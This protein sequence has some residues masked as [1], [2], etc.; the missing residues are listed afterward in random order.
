MAQGGA[1]KIGC[2]TTST[3][4][5]PAWLTTLLWAGTAALAAQTPDTPLTALADLLDASESPTQSALLAQHLSLVD[6]QLFHFCQDRGAQY[7]SA[8]NPSRALRSYS[9]ALAVAIKLED[10]LAVAQA[11]S[12][13][14]LA[15]YRQGRM[16][17]ALQAYQNGLQA[18]QSSGAQPQVAELLRRIGVAERALGDMTA[19]SAADEQSLEIFQRLDDK[20]GVI[21][22]LNGMGNSHARLGELRQAAENF[23]QCS[24]LGKAAGSKEIVAAAT[25]SLGNVYSMQGDTAL[26]LTYLEKALILKKEANASKRDLAT[27]YVNLIAGYRQVGRYQDALRAADRCLA[28]AREERDE[29]TAGYALLNRAHVYQEAHRYRES[30]ADA[31]ASL[32]IHEKNK[33]PIEVAA[34]LN[35]IARIELDLG[36]NPS[37]LDTARRASE[38]ARQ[39]SAPD[40]LW[41]ALESEAIAL[42]RLHQSQLALAAYAEGAATVDTL[43]QRLAGGEAQGLEFLRDKMNL[44]YGLME[45]SIQL[46]QAEEAL[47]V[48]ER[49]KSG[50]ILDVLRAGR[51]R[52]TT[53]MTLAEQHRE[54][55]LA[56]RLSTVK[57]PAAVRD[58]E[59]FRSEL[60]AA[61]PGLKVRRGICDPVSVEAAA[62]LLPDTRTALLEF[63]VA[64]AATYLFVIS[65]DGAGSPKL[66]LH[67]LPWKQEDL[68]RE[69]EAFRLKLASRDLSYRPAA[70]SLYRRLLGPAAEALKNK[71]LLA[72]VPDGPLWS[73]PF[74]ALLQPNGRHVIED[75]AVF[76]APSFT[77]LVEMVRSRK[78]VL[79]GARTLLAMGDPQVKLG[80]AAREVAALGRLYGSGSV[81]LTGT[82]ASESQWKALAPQHRILHLAT[83]GVLNSANPLY[84]YVLLS[85]GQG[86]DGIVEAREILDLDLKAELVVLSAC[87]TGRGGFRHGEGLVGLSW[88]L[89]VAGSP[90]S[91][92]S[93]W[94]VNSA[95]TTD[96]MLAFHRALKQHSVTGLGGKAGA[97][98]AASLQ[99]MK[100]VEFRHPFYWAGFVLVG[101]GY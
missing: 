85:P 54:Q 62:S 75:K 4:Y 25:E 17:E 61:H 101:D 9:S 11:Y 16:L 34:S 60:Y 84:S 27:S 63:A 38:I 89:M 67:K 70:A 2:P 5:L 40:L 57:T 47:K 72:I 50:L 93:Q 6:S 80:S 18:A 29:A 87:E 30:L 19:A 8:A 73:L 53:A 88:A 71:T 86:E 49:A 12:Q 7:L 22:V 95:S 15:E 76:Y 1:A 45:G 69:V 94:K 68:A 97:L 32:A 46:G 23:Q 14:G 98:R 42:T 92:V 55:E 39:I 90:A 91:L 83:H 37:A 99:I 33:T 10:P 65:R 96:L 66:E 41:Q 64:P 56:A 48:A 100:S 52:I 79:Q 43:R 13:I 35:L 20:M 21:K 82:A 78:P 31:F 77:V 28:L 3:K 59:A 51:A 81:T 24:R 36:R 26:A 44:Y 58:L 74:Q